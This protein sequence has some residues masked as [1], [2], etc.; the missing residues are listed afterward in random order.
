M[1]GIVHTSNSEFSPLLKDKDNLGS[2]DNGPYL[3]PPPED[4]IAKS[5]II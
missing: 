5:V 4:L 1:G 2:K 3:I